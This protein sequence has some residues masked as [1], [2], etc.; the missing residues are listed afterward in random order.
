MSVYDRMTWY[1]ADGQ[2][3]TL[4]KLRGANGRYMPTVEYVDAPVV[5]GHGSRVRS[6]RFGVGQI[7][8]PVRVEGFNHALMRDALRKYAAR[9]D[10]T[11]GDGRLVSAI[12]GRL[13]RQ[14]ACRYL[15]GMNVAGRLPASAAPVL[16]FRT[17]GEPFWQDLVDTQLSFTSN[18]SS[19]FLPI[20][21]TN[22]NFVNLTTTSIFTA[23]TVTNAGDVDAWPVWTI[24]GPCDAN[25][26]ALKRVNGATVRTLW[27]Q[28]A[29]ADGEVVTL[30]CRPGAKTA[31]L[32]DGSSVFSSLNVLYGPPDFWPL[33][34]GPNVV[35]LEMGGTSGGSKVA[36]AF[37]RQ[38]LSA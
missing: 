24:T 20:P 32:S 36:L 2:A 26:V 7:L 28:R 12:D 29:L 35:Q 8:V 22:G 17:V 27:L 34:G 14:I 16:L 30:D 18:P 37:R 31:L 25:G 5:Q 21:G 9:L 33:A 38:F 11:R 3:L 13:P 19:A 10:P 15:S 6:V 1:D 4:V 23:A